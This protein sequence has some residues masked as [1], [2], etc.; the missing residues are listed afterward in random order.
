MP[1]KGAGTVP[2]YESGINPKANFCMNEFVAVSG[3][4]KHSV[5]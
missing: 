4:G 1:E 3:V 2:G 5:N